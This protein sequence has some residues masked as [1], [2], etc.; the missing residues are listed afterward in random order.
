MTP[1]V[2]YLSIYFLPVATCGECVGGFVVGTTCSSPVKAFACVAFGLWGGCAIGFIT[3]YFTSFS[4]APVR[5]IPNACR[6]GAATNIIYG[7]AAGYLSVFL[8][9]FIL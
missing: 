3:E 1:V 2:Y 6:T 4:Y 8:P 7:L 5:E 9:V